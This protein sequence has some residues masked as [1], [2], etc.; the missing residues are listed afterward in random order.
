MI[1]RFLAFILFAVLAS[2]LFG[3]NEILRES[4]RDAGNT[5]VRLEALFGV[6]AKQG[7]LPYRITIRNNS[8]ADRNWTLRINEGGY[9]RSLVTQWSGT[10][11]VEN[12]TEVVRDIVL[13]FAPGF[14]GYTYRNVEVNFL[15]PGLN[16][17]SRSTGYQVNDSFPT[18]AVSKRIAAR[19][20]AKL[21]DL[22]RKKNSSNQRFGDSFEPESLPGDWKAYTGLDALLIDFQTWNSIQSRAKRALLEWVRLG[23]TLH[24][25]YSEQKYPEFDFSDL[26]IEGLVVNP[27][28]NDRG[29]LTLGTV[30]TYPWDGKELGSSV[31]SRY[32]RMDSHSDRLDS[33]YRDE[34]QLRELL[35]DKPFNSILIFG[36]L[37]SFAIL[38]APVNLFYFAGKGRRHRL[39]Y[40]T[41]IISVSA[42]L[43]IVLLIFLGDGLGGKGYRTALVDLQ[44]SR[45]ERRFFVTQEQFSRTGVIVNSGFKIQKDLLI[46]PLRT[47]ESVYAAFNRRSGR[48]TTYSFGDTLF[49]G[50]FFRSRSEQGFLARAVEPTRAR[51]EMREPQGDDSPPVL[52][53]NLPTAVREFYFRDSDRL[54]WKSNPG[55][56]ASPGDTLPLVA[57][58]EKELRTFLKSNSTRFGSTLLQSIERIGEEPGRFFALPADVAPYFIETHTGIRW[59]DDS[60]LLTG[61][62][63]TTTPS[64][65]P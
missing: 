6:A 5:E 31:P 51:I 4:H 61:S 1:H 16:A 64:S 52:V 8:G 33:Q 42:C 17:I 11:A 2:P 57:S 40:T 45:S 28:E 32:E 41:P 48:S 23:G 46:E 59:A 65:A 18:L 29:K 63:D 22:V 37:L 10:I 14:L 36:I 26:K 13:P 3:G 60:L 19:S 43:V 9:R 54:V 21:D 53:S 58:T 15:S 55:K 56:A 12:G 34:W 39:F 38:V 50:G 20:L 35:G 44:S 49:S 24:V 62:L 47:P 25:Y 7:A 30:Q 27:G